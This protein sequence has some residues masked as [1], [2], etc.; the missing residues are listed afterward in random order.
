[1]TYYYIEVTDTAKSWVEK[2]CIQATD[3]TAV[4][5]AKIEIGWNGIRCNRKDC[6]GKIELRPRG[7]DRVA[8]IEKD[9][10]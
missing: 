1:M 5:R 8:T 7:M 10:D 6:G 9:R 3:V 2:F 4:R